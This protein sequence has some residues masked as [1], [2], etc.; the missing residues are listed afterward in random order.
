[1]FTSVKQRFSF[2]NVPPKCG[3]I[4]AHIH[5]LINYPIRRILKTKHKVTFSTFSCLQQQQQKRSDK[6]LCFLNNP[7]FQFFDSTIGQKS[8]IEYSFRQ[9]RKHVFGNPAFKDKLAIS[10][11]LN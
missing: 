10:H 1:M 11:S 5:C 4:G 2:K 6:K 3:A 8:T 9:E 7:Q